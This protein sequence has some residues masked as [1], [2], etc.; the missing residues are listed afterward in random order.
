MID[1]LEIGLFEAK[2]RFSELV[3]T[4]ISGREIVVTRRGEPVVRIVPYDPPA[5]RR[6]EAL[7]GLRSIRARAAPGPSA[8]ELRD[9]GRR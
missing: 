8:R 1:A 7:A 4:C 5:R 9:E 6:V 2:T 3:E